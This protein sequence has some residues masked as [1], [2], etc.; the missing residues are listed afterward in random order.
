MI[1]V[2]ANA[3]KQPNRENKE[4]YCRKNVSNNVIMSARGRQ[5]AANT[6]Y[7]TQKSPTLL[8]GLSS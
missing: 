1:K 5:R 6:D 7:M 8:V 4:E 3:Q 2:Q